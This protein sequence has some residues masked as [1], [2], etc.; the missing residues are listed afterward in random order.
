VILLESFEK[1]DTIYKEKRLLF[2]WKRR[3]GWA[4]LS[5]L[6][7]R[8][9]REFNYCFV[10][11]ESAEMIFRVATRFLRQINN[12]YVRSEILFVRPCDVAKWI[13]HVSSYR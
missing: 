7:N 3:Q 6:G 12:F 13:I 8:R 11:F 4:T 1:K 9:R 2:R 5:F 10:E